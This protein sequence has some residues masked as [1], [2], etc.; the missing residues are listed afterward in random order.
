MRDR[1]R[2]ERPLNLCYCS[3]M[4]DWFAHTFPALADLDGPKWIALLL[5]V[6]MF[7]A[8]AAGIGQGV[9]QRHCGEIQRV[10][11]ECPAEIEA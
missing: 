1:A 9:K 4:R 11:P 7:F 5:T 8:V 6:A 3:A 10:T 2:L